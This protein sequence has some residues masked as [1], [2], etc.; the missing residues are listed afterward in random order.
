MK[1]QREH[2]WFKKKKKSENCL[3]I[4]Q[5]AQELFVNH[6]FSKVTMEELANELG[7]SKKTVYKDFQSKDELLLSILNHTKDEMSGRFDEILHDESMT[8]PQRMVQIMTFI[9]KKISNMR[10]RFMDDLR[11]TRPEIFN[12][13]IEFRR[14]H[15]H[16]FM[17]EL[18]EE[19]KRTGYINKEISTV[20]LVSGYEAVIQRLMHPDFLTQHPLKPEEVYHSILQIFFNGA[21]VEDKRDEFEP[22]TH[23]I[24]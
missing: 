7:M 8:F 9:S 6:S 15:I 14:D 22:I 1:K 4:M 19:G 18:M 5:K 17:S 24:K 20:V 3:R 10:P 21:L 11:R 23:I 12:E 2:S 13:L 16:R